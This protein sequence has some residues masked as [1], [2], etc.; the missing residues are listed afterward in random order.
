MA[1]ASQRL[2]LRCR[3]LA[4]QIRRC[5]PPPA[6]QLRPGQARLR[7]GVPE[8]VR[9]AQLGQRPEAA[10][11]AA[12]GELLAEGVQGGAPVL[13]FVPSMLSGTT[14]HLKRSGHLRECPCR[15]LDC[16][17]Q[18]ADEDLL[19]TPLARLTCPCHC[20]PAA[21]VGECRIRHVSAT[22]GSSVRFALAV[23]QEVHQF[24][25]GA[26]HAA[27]STHPPSLRI[28][29]RHVSQ[30]EGVLSPTKERCESAA[31]ISGIS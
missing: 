2:R 23:A 1:D 17:E 7:G 3:K 19:N 13:G 15:C 21:Q 8:L 27:H 24:P 20:L 11:P 10:G 16:A 14:C 9:P 12:R 30:A 31:R 25:R 18:G 26:R 28:P 22:E 5:L 29:L 4:E 6:P